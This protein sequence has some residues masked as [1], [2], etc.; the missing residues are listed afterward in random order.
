MKQFLLGCCLLLLPPLSGRAADAP[1]APTPEA[2]ALAA[3]AFPNGQ[4]RWAS[5]LRSSAPFEFDDPEHPGQYIGFEYEI[6]SAIAQ[7]LG[8]TLEAEDVTWDGLIP[9]LKTGNAYD[10][11]M[12]GIEYS[13]D[14]A[15]E[16]DFTRSYYFSF[17]QLVTRSD[18]GEIAKLDQ[19]RGRPV[20]TLDQTGAYDLLKAAGA[21]IR[22]YDE[23]INAYN[24][25]AR[26]RLEAVLLDYPIAMYYGAPNHNLR[27][28]GPPHGEIT[29]VIAVRKGNA[30]VLAAL[31]YGINQLIASGR[32][33]EILSRWNLWTELAAHTFNQPVE[34]AGPPTAYEAFVARVGRDVTW[35]ERF[36]RLWDWREMLGWAA[37]NT[38]AISIFS[39]A[40]AVAVG[41]CLA[42]VRVFAARPL[43]WLAMAYVELVRGTPLLIQLLFIYYGLPNIG[44]KLSPWCAGILGLGLNYAAYEAENYRAGL[45]SV[46]RGQMEAA[47]AL[48]MTRQQALL[49]VVVPRACRLVL[50][51]LTNDFLSLLKDSSLVS[52]IAIMDLTNA[53]NRM[54][55]T[56][57]DY[58]GVGLAIAVIYLLLGLPFVRLA[59]WA[60]QRL[61]VDTRPSS[62]R[63]GLLPVRS[64]KPDVTGP[65]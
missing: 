17:E 23:E 41:F 35:G 5:D 20:G 12:C 34:P 1:V 19:L 55:T 7:D 4:L 54:A 50:P 56:Y 6:I 26:G 14:R 49:H 10:C 15:R 52:M 8:V 43:Q 47:R 40:L 3:K 16:V 2:R 24:D 51:P 46:P 30:D 22:T 57:Y 37:V 21:D 62:Q 28:N 27:F 29:Y 61:A 44:I 38:L 59:R 32:L 58:F 31:N 60:E 64:R 65:V 63:P 45:L 39:M 33:R 36:Q 48:G 25:C 13:E 11:V 18:T 42:V 9:G 53:Y